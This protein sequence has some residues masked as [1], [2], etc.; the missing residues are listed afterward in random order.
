[1]RW[2]GR[3]AVALIVATTGAVVAAPAGAAPPSGRCVLMAQEPDERTKTIAFEEVCGARARAADVVALARYYQDAGWD[4]INQDVYG[5]FG[6]CDR[7]GYTF[8]VSGWWADNL[9]SYRVFG[10][11][12][13]STVT[14]WWGNTRYGAIGDQWYVGDAWNDDVVRFRTWSR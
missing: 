12:Y 13:Y 11:C 1:M 7:E 3:A 4:G 5:A 8:T 9:S 2:A 10:N 14:N 6:T